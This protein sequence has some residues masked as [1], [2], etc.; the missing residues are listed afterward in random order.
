[1]AGYSRHTPFVNLGRW[2]LTI[3][4]G[5]HASTSTGLSWHVA[6][7]QAKRCHS[8]GYRVRLYRCN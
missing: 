2:T 6:A 7:S 3:V 4:S 1:M 8:M 5:D